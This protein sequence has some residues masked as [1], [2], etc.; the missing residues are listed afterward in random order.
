MGG[1]MVTR[2]RCLGCDEVVWC[3]WCGG[4]RRCKR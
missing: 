4:V 3:M 2:M 1:E